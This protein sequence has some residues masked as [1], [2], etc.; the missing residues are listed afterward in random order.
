VS[1]PNSDPYRHDY[2][3][4]E[5]MERVLAGLSPGQGVSILRL[6]PYWDVVARIKVGTGH[7]REYVVTDS[8]LKDRKP[9]VVHGPV[10]TEEEAAE[11]A[12]STRLLWTSTHVFFAAD[13]PQM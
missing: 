13:E 3:A 10:K 11:W 1:K 2:P 5:S 6:P 12:R 7:V 4:G 9:Q 8:S